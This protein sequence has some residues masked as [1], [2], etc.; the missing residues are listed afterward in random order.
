M[1]AETTERRPFTPK[2]L[3]QVFVEAGFDASEAE[4]CPLP[5]DAT[6]KARELEQLKTDYTALYDR[7]TRVNAKLAN[8]E[9]VRKDRD[10]FATAQREAARRRVDSVNRAA[11]ERAALI[12]RTEAQGVPVARSAGAVRIYDD[13]GFEYLD[14][15]EGGGTPKL[16]PGR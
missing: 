3:A 12:A 5:T 10:R 14:A 2:T 13:A 1:N 6:H 8:L 15:R 4:P 9:S 7:V 16:I 11:A